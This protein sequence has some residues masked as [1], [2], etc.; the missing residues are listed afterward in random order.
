MATG[1]EWIQAISSAVGAW[2]VV[3]SAL[4]LIPNKERRDDAMKAAQQAEQAYKLLQ[5]QTAK[6]LEYPICKAHWPPEI[7]LSKGNLFD[8]YTEQFECPLC[9]SLWPGRDPSDDL[10]MNG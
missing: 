6:S 8:P 5:A 9:K 7:M 4:E 1:P 10:A 3:K 2:P